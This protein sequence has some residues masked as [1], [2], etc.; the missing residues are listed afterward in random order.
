[1]FKVYVLV[2]PKPVFI[3]VSNIMKPKFLVGRN[4]QLMYSYSKAFTVY[5]NLRQDSPIQSPYCHAHAYILVIGCYKTAL[6]G[7]MRVLSRITTVI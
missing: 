6:V 5:I 7:K 4:V 1:M 2:C 3:R